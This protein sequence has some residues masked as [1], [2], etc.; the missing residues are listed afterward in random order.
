M[1]TVNHNDVRAWSVERL[2]EAV[3]EFRDGLA[4]FGPVSVRYELAITAGND[5]AVMDGV[6]SLVL[7]D[8]PRRVEMSLD[9]M[10]VYSLPLSVR[11]QNRLVAE[12]FDTLGKVKGLTLRRVLSMPMMGRRG[13]RE[14]QDLLDSH[15]V[16]MPPGSWAFI[17]G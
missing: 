3:A 14:I 8:S 2:K 10:S 6:V 9:H 17:T 7:R 12:G 13:L 15:N 11:V 1:D 5:R 4:P 16:D